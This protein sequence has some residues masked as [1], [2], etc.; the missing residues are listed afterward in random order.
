M[1]IVL[2]IGILIVSIF[3]LVK[4]C[5]VFITNAEKIGIAIGTPQF[6]IGVLF[7]GIGTSLPELV[8]SI[9]AINANSSEIV[10]GNVLGSNIINL[11]L[12]LGIVVF[13]EKEIHIGF[14]MMKL[15]IPY[16][17]GSSFLIALMMLDGKI[18][19][20]EAVICLFCFGAYAFSS[21]KE[22]MVEKSKEKIQPL[23]I[24]LFILSPIVIFFSG[25]YMVDSVIKISGF[26]KVDM[27]AIS[28]SVVAFG[29]FLPDIVISIQAARKKKFELILGNIIGGNV[30]KSFAVM[31]IPALIHPLTISPIIIKFCVP[32]SVA[33]T[34]L[35][36]FVIFDKKINRGEGAL[37]LLFYVFFILKLFQV[38]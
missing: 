22:K 38:V 5:N 23:M 27:A 30:F 12:L 32:V 19:R 11:L 1:S 37:L 4:S 20:G 7:V 6:I 14:D 8:S 33:S 28:F 24:I 18:S 35:F 10:I 36:I 16:L 31:G 15:D 25:K 9:F 2:W 26:L 34:V 13:I 29:T 21:M 17:L 3:L